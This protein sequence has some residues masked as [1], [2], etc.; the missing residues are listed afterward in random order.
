MQFNRVSNSEVPRVP[1]IAAHRAAAAVFMVPR[2]G[3]EPTLPLRE[4]G[5]SSHYGF[6]RQ[7]KTLFVGWTMPSSQ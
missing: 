7:R 4:N 2:V 5:F 6:H 1:E 3:L